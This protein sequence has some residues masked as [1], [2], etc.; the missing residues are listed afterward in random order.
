MALIMTHSICQ[1]ED[2]LSAKRWLEEPRVRGATVGFVPTMGA[3]HDGHLSL[4][5]RARAENELV[6]VSVFVNPLQFDDPGDLLR[7]PRDLARDAAL[8]EGAG[9]D[10]VFTGTLVGEGGFF[11][12]C[13]DAREVPVEAPGPAALGLEGAL[14]EGHFEGVATIVR[15]L[16]ETVRPHRAYFGA[17]DYQQ[18]LVVRDLAARMR[19]EGA[20]APEIVV[21][22]IA[23]E[24]HGLAR[25][26]RNELL[27]AW[28]R[29][30]ASALAGT[31]QVA[32]RAWSAGVRDAELLTREMRSAFC[33]L[34]PVSF[35]LE[36]AAVRDPKAWTTEAPESELG[37]GV[38]LIAARVPAARGGVVRLIDNAD[39]TRTETLVRPSG[40]SAV[41]WVDCVAPA[42]LNPELRVLQRRADGYHEVDLTMLA[43]DL[44]DDVRVSWTDDGVEREAAE[45]CPM[46]R[47]EVHGPAASEDIPAGPSNLAARAAGVVLGHVRGRFP[48]GHVELHIEKRIPSRAGLGGGSSDAAAAFLGTLEL[49]AQLGLELDVAPDD[50]GLASE[51]AD[52]GADCAFFLE[53]AGYARCR[54]R[55]ELV[56]ALDRGALEAELFTVVTPKLECPTGA[57]FGELEPGEGHVPGPWINALEAAAVRAVPELG[58]F[59]EELADLGGT[60]QLAGSG[61]SYFRREERPPKPETVGDLSQALGALRYRGVHRPFGSGAAIKRAFVSSRGGEVGL[62]VGAAGARA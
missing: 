5:E 4:V 55:G 20:P 1:L 6:V 31:L 46:L 51:L 15:R 10:M 24:A 7:Y 41:A 53:P 45:L 26:S 42:K 39:L 58:A 44:V 47:V 27:D 25:S 34:A 49:M 11:P 38:A 35:E 57:V 61:A 60:W 48:A 62:L 29:E 16:F 12:E 21:C 28:T 54:G 36:Y 30:A 3:L 50:P 19:A 18:T 56:T 43:I 17:K 9:C 13:R 33:A 14:R 37:S 8:L 22:P 2:P 52:L 59:R 32:A 40:S 23:R